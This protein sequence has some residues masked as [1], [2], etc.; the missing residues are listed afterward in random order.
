ML[1]VILTTILSWEAFK[2]LV[3]ELWFKIINKL[4]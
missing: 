1:K 2:W 3:T 4:D